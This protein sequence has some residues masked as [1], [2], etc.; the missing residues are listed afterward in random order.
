MP[1]TR[2]PIYTLFIFIVLLGF[3]KCCSQEK[4]QNKEADRASQEAVSDQRAVEAASNTRAVVDAKDEDEANAKDEADAKGEA[5]LLKLKLT[6][7]QIIDPVYQQAIEAAA[8][9]RAEADAITAALQRQEEAVKKAEGD[10][11]ICQETTVSRS[12]PGFTMDFV[13]GK[14]EHMP[15]R[16]QVDGAYTTAWQFIDAFPSERNARF[17]TKSAVRILEG[18]SGAIIKRENLIPIYCELVVKELQKEGQIYGEINLLKT[19]PTE[20]PGSLQQV[21]RTE[22]TGSGLEAHIMFI[23]LKFCQPVD[24]KFY[25]IITI[26]PAACGSTSSLHNRSLESFTCN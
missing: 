3:I 23:S 17:V 12:F 6:G 21:C 1:L 20:F 5:D 7:T 22:L 18:P 15:R 11:S 26:Q 16:V 4:K 2:L 25:R 19:L 24:S 9:A 8:N 10:S 13:S 14:P